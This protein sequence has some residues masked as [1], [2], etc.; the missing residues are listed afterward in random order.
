[1]KI[2]A[3]VQYKSNLEENRGFISKNVQQMAHGIV[4]IFILSKKNKGLVDIV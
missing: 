3:V 4:T 2:A 1:M